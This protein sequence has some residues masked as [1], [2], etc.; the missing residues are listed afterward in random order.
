MYPN[1]KLE[2]TLVFQNDKQFH[3]APSQYNTITYEIKDQNE[4]NK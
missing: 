3:Y 2:R 4:A 1:K